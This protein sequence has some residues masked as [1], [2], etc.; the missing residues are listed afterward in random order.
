MPSMSK[1][2]HQAAQQ[3][4]NAFP[5][6]QAIAALMDPE[7]W[8]WESAEIGQPVANPVLRLTL[9][10]EH[11]QVRVLGE[12]AEAADM[13]LSRYITQAALLVARSRRK[14]FDSDE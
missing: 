4:A 2:K 3:Q 12:A 8:D 14:P 5:D 11:D 1:V 10:L 6:E 7:S 9:R 13:P